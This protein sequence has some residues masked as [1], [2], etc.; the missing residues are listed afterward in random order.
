MTQPNLGPR[1]IWPLALLP[2][3]W[4]LPQHYLPWL[5]A[6]QDVTALAL[7]VV[8]GL[9]CRGDQAIPR[10]WMLGGI[11]ALGCIAAQRLAGAITFG[12]DAWMAG[13][14]VLSFTGAIAVGQSTARECE[15][16]GPRWLD[17]F[18]I[19]T[20]SAAVASVAIALMQW[21]DAAPLPLP[22]AA[23]LPGDRPYANFAQANNFC[24]AVFL[25]LC[26]L[27]W[28]RESRRIGTVGWAVGAAFLLFGMTMSG[29]RTGWVQVAAAAVLIAWRG[30]RSPGAVL[31]LPHALAL[32][33]ALAGFTLAWPALNDTLLLS[34]SRSAADQAQAGLRLPI[35]QLAL[36]AISRQPL[37]GYGWQQIPA[38]QWAVALDHAPLQRYF[39]HAHNLVLDL[40]LWAGVPVGGFIAGCAAWALWRQARAIDDARALWLFAGVLGFVAH[41]LLEMPHAYAYLLLPVGVALG[42]VHALCPGQPALRLRPALA[43]TAWAAMGVALVLS[44]ADYLEVEQNYRLARM[45]STFGERRIVTPPP[46]TR[47]L[48]QLGAFMRF[49]RVEARAGM[50]SAEVEA[51][52]S[53]AM[54]YAHPP[55]L[56]RLALA[57]GLNGQPEAARDTLRRLCAMHVAARCTEGRESWLALQQQ[58][59]VLAAVPAPDVPMQR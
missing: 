43:R 29:S 8:A 2:G 16:R 11:V 46:E 15:A 51:M 58:Y 13:L 14:Y 34:S 3:V 22:V 59:P 20:S 56:L 27:C 7:L 21:T 18:A 52:R 9:L 48:S 38:A 5:A 10:A 30:P 55:V 47:V 45:E 25:G 23:I 35:W 49:I 40:M 12:G 37:W 42:V 1:S 4:L 41:A 39:E 31:R 50:T 33:A 57:E 32:L 26:S 24:T 17:L 19:G 53:V 36:D 6:H 28:L 54:R 44:A